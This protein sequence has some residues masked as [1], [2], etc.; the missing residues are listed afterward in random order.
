MPGAAQPSP[1]RRYAAKRDAILVAASK[2][3]TDNGAS[4][5]TLAAVAK[6]M[7]LHPVSLTY[8]Y[9]RKEDLAAACILH[10]ITRLS[11]MLAEAEAEPSPT[12][13][14]RRFITAYYAARRRILEDGE[15]QFVPMGEIRTIGA[16]YEDSLVTA[17]QAFSQRLTSLLKDSEAPLSG[18]RRRAL[19][20]LLINQLFWSDTWIGAYQVE[21]YGRIGER[22]ADIIIGGLA[23][24]GR[25][26]PETPLLALGAP[27]AD[28]DEITRERFL[29]AATDLINQEGYRG[30]SVD[31]ISAR[32]NVTKGSFYHHNSDKDGL[33]LACFER[34]FELI[35]EA[36]RKAAPAADGWERLWLAA[37]SL[38]MHQTRGDRGRLLRHHAL[39]ALPIET[40]KAT[41]A[42]F[43]QI[44]HA[45]AGVI[46]DGVMDGS[47]RPVDPLLAAQ[48]VMAMFNCALPLDYW[49]PGSTLETVM[50]A[51]VRPALMG[52]FSP[53]TA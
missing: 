12:E 35:D 18:G 6:R 30:A 38:A 40:R 37:A 32:L 44:A 45:F 14:L 10:T 39:A 15:P 51:H 43:Q 29:I 20:H 9:K 49:T 13:R 24:P 41:M 17:Y 47:I 31:K 34:S 23:A 48:L 46:S 19:T 2:V 27:P 28:N 36:K 50:D 3:F 22:V 21:D 1:S 7:D 52:V 42:R 16:P 4:G 53:A 25:A 8:Y 33:V 11:D 5:F 26:S